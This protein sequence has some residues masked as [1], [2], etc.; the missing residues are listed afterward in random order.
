MR[1]ARK[2]L[3]AMAGLEPVVRARRL[4]AFL[5]RR[6]YEIDAIRSAL[7]RLDKEAASTGDVE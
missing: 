6:G 1:A 2:K 3:R 4:T 5:A 7:R